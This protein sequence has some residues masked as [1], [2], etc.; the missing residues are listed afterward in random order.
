MTEDNEYSTVKIPTDLM[1]EVDKL[2]GQHG[3]KSRAEIV[4]Q[5]LRVLLQGYQE[6][7]HAKQ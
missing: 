1:S 7:R 5:A 4:K 2:V 3:F 6:N